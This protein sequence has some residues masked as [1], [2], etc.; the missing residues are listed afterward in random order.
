MLTLCT[1][2]NYH[3]IP[4]E[5]VRTLIFHYQWADYADPIT[6]LDNYLY[7]HIHDDVCWR[8][9][10]RQVLTYRLAQLLSLRGRYGDAMHWL[11]RSTTDRKLPGWD[12]MVY[13]TSYYLD[14]ETVTP[15]IPP[16][17]CDNVHLA[18]RMY[19]LG[20]QGVWDYREAWPEGV[21]LMGGRV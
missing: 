16:T 11:A 18:W 20:R 6:A 19:W 7:H 15:P 5:S 1:S 14:G 10:P 9:L 3:M 13:L 4:I 12:N 8:L 21:A 2:Y 17:P